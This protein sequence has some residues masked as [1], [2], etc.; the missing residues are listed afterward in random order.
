MSNIHEWKIFNCANCFSLDSQSSY[1]FLRL[2]PCD[3]MDLRS[4]D[5][6]AY[7]GKMRV[8]KEAFISADETEAHRM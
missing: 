3:C 4:R 1:I 8:E 7:N 5:T 6:K 2:L